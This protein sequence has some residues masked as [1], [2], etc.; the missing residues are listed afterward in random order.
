MKGDCLDEKN[1]IMSNG[2]ENKI[3]HKEHKTNYALFF[4]KWAK[5]KLEKTNYQEKFWV[6]LKKNKIK[7]TIDL[8]ICVCMSVVLEKHKG[9]C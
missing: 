1:D 4:L 2:F 6:Q 9:K 3:R 8:L 5:L 7:E